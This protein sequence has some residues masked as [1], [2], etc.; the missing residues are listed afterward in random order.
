MQLQPIVYVT[1]MDRAVGWYTTLVGVEPA[2]TSEHWTSFPVSGANLALHLTDER[3]TAGGV[4][5]SLV[6]DE[7]LET[8][9]Q[10]V[11]AAVGITEQPFGRSIVVVDPDGTRIQVN[12]HAAH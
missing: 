1:D 5:L 11:D 9:L 12:E 6:T 4:E 8:V 2:M 10:R 7:P 3:P